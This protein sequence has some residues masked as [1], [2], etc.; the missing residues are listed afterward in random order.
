LQVAAL[1]SA[2]RGAGQ[3]ATPVTRQGR[4]RAAE[5]NS[6]TAADIKARSKGLRDELGGGGHKAGSHCG[7]SLVIRPEGAAQVVLLGP[8]AAGK[9]ALQLR[10]TGSH[11]NV[12]RY[13]FTTQFPE[14]GMLPFEDR[15]FQLVDV[16]AI[17][18]EHPVPRLGTTLQAADMRCSSS[19]CASSRSCDSGVVACRE[20]PATPRTRP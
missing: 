13:T 4:S 7:P 2:R 9:S 18:P 16:P 17:A 15:Q 5:R 8:P 1:R 12:A 10:L 19:A 3:S 20:E 11:A 14:P 6:A